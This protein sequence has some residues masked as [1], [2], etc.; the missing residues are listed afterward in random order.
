MQA[1]K[2]LLE[3]HGIQVIRKRAQRLMRT[4]GLR[5]IYRRSSTSRRRRS[6][7]YPYLFGNLPGL[8][9]AVISYI[10]PLVPVLSE[11]TYPRF[12]RVKFSPLATPSRT[13]LDP[14]KLTAMLV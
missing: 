1:E 4:M 12:I 5:D 10:R 13:S 14:P 9:P 2:A 8:R 6:T 11:L 3:R 7:R